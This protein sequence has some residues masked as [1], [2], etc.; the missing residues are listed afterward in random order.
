MQK[1]E[2]KLYIFL[3]LFLLFSPIST[4]AISLDGE[5]LLDNSENKIFG[6]SKILGF[7]FNT[8]LKFE[9]TA[10]VLS[11]SIFVDCPKASRK[12]VAS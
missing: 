4:H 1:P 5:N 11:A 9:N 8:Y 10:S 3:I 2:I 6:D 12:L 7:D